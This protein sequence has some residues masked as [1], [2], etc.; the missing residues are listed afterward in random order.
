MMPSL[1]ARRPA[2]AAETVACLC[3]LAGLLLTF[4]LLFQGSYA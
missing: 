2:S 3:F 4:D 1:R